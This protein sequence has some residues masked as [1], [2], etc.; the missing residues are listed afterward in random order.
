MCFDEWGPLE[1][2]PIGGIAWA[3]QKRPVRMRATYSRRKGTEQFLAFYDVHADSINGIFRKHKRVVDISE[4]FQKLR[5]CYPH[6]KL[7]VILDNLHNVHDHPRFLTLLKKL[8]IQP[9]WT[10]TESS[11]LSS[12][13]AT[14]GAALAAASTVRFL[15]G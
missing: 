10:P 7:F 4:A 13:L 15:F 11:W 1:L 2:K 6:R 14:L 9:V 8:H 12:L 5:R 3:Q